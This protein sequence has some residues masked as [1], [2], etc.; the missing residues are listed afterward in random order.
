[1]RWAMKLTLSL[2]PA[3]LAIGMGAAYALGK[4]SIGASIFNVCIS[5][6]LF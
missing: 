1:M 6:N 5:W 3:V 2:S 4:T